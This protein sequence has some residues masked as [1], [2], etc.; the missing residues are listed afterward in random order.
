MGRDSRKVSRELRSSEKIHKSRS[1]KR[2]NVFN[3]KTAE[4]DES[5]QS[6]SSKKL[7]QNTEDDVPED[8][9]T[10]FRIIN[11]IQVFTAISALIKCKKCDGN[12]VFQTASTRGLGF[13]IVVAC[14]NCGNEYIP[15]CSFVGH[16]YEI[17]RRFIFVMRIL[18]IGYEGLCKF[19]GLMDMPSFLDKSTHT[20]LLK[21]ILNCS[22]AVAET[23][24]TKAVNEEKQ[25]MPT[26]E[27]EDI[28]H[29]TVSGD[30]TWQKRGYTSSFGVSSI[31]GYFTGKILDINIK[32]AYCKLCEYWK[33]KTNTVEFEE[34]YQ[35]H[36]DVCSA[37][38]QGSSGKMEVDAMVE[39]FSY[40][41]T[42]YG[43]KYANYIGDG[44]S[45]TYSGIIKSDPYENTT[46]NKKECIG[47]VQKRMG[48]RLRT[49]KSKQ[50]GL[51]GRGKLTGKLIDKLT[52]YYGLAIRRH[53]DSIENMKSAIMATFYHYGSS[54]E[55]PNHD[56]CP[57]GEESWC[58]YQRAEARGELDTFSHDYSPLPSDVLKAIKPIYEDLSNENLLS[59]CVGGFNQN[60]NESF[61]QLVWK[62]CPKTDLI[63]G[64]I[65]IGM[66]K[67]W[68]LH[69]SK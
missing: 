14:N 62:I 12:V 9:S 4:R 31:I 34:W 67:E 11:F 63:V 65:L 46:V 32:S 40:S 55:K 48:S 52:V 1:V 25:A 38:H 13:K 69:V 60:N 35:S 37:N 33:K 61:N 64:L 58:S 15:S 24:M 42:K 17:N 21:Q 53:C 28:N 8:S 23:F 30:G 5:I 36:E 2:K 56:M 43:V 26:T 3:P 10:E 19:C 57:K 68:M 6:T 44:D 18:G 29:L 27:N 7:K 54:D 16:S 20:I 45:K 66:Q 47:H 50:K 49:L 51:G 39:M 22:K 41:E 59:R